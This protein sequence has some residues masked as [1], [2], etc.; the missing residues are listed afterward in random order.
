MTRSISLALFFVLVLVA[1][2]WLTTN[3]EA[4]VVNTENSPRVQVVR[5]DH[6]M[7]VP[8]FQLAISS[9]P[10]SLNQMNREALS[11]A[12]RVRDSIVTL[13][14]GYRSPQGGKGG[15]KMADEIWI[16]SGVIL[17]DGTNILGVIPPRIT[18]L[19]ISVSFQDGSEVRADFIGRDDA[20]ELA[21]IRLEAPSSAKPLLWRNRRTLDWGEH[22]YAF[23]RNPVHGLQMLRVMVSGEAAYPLPDSKNTG[24]HYWQ[25]DEVLPPDFAGAVLLDGEGHVAGLVIQPDAPDLLRAL[26][27]DG[28]SIRVAAEALRSLQKTD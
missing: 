23:A 4:R 3:R 16:S 8:K 28:G 25:L 9:D 17:G 27:L 20:T 14:V 10:S 7:A 26:V 6:E 15:K 19:N 21:L 5:P 22:F 13:S 24:P 12:N 18:P 2:F 1:V 11:V